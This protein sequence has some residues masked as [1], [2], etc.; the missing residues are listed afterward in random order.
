[1]RFNVTIQPQE[2][3]KSARPASWVRR[4]R[5]RGHIMLIMAYFVFFIRFLVRKCRLNVVMF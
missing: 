1:M 2:A 4:Y 5:D 3:V